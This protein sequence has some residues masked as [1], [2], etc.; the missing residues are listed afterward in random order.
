MGT[1]NHN[2]VIATTSSRR[3]ILRLQEFV[4][5]L[6]LYG[7][8]LFCFGK[9]TMNGMSTIVMLPDG[10]NEG[11]HESAIGDS[12][13]VKFIA[14]LEKANDEDGCN[15]WHFIEVGYGEFG[16]KIL[17]G[18]CKNRYNDLDYAVR[19]SYEF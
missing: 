18:N 7:R 1:I 6:P 19:H 13:R 11:W 2:A 17:R 16:Q 3:E 14:E 9:P 5:H 15:P 10:S 8:I 4:D 12:F